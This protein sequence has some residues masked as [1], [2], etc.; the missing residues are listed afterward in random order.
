MATI[1]VDVFAQLTAVRAGVLR[2]GPASDVVRTARESSVAPKYHFQGLRHASSFDGNTASRD[3]ALPVAILI[4]AQFRAALGRIVEQQVA[5]AEAA[6]TA[7]AKAGAGA[8]TGGAAAAAAFDK[9]TAWAAAAASPGNR[10]E[11]IAL[12]SVH[13]ALVKS[14]VLVE[15]DLVAT[16]VRPAVL[17]ATPPAAATDATTFA[18]QEASINAGWAISLA[19]GSNA[20]GATRAELVMLNAAGLTALEAELAYALFSMGQAAPV[21]AGAQLFIDGHPT[22]PMPLPAP[23][24]APLRRRSLPP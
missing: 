10:L 8:T 7:A 4:D 2:N 14:Y 16:E 1:Q 20:T 23:G 9:D 24:T 13:A 22:I 17:T 3:S 11:A 19:S 5:D 21:R 12:G 6:H 18:A 15:G